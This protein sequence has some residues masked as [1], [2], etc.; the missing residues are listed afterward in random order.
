MSLTSRLSASLRR[1]QHWSFRFASIRSQEGVA[2][3]YARIRHPKPFMRRCPPPAPSGPV[4]IIGGDSGDHHQISC[5]ILRAGLTVASSNGDPHNE[6]IVINPALRD[7]KLVSPN[8]LVILFGYEDLRSTYL[9]LVIE[10]GGV[11]LC[12]N[13]TILGKLQSLGLPLERTYTFKNRGA[14]CQGM[15]RYLLAVRSIHLE[16]YEWSEISGLLDLPQNPKLCLSLPEAAERRKRFTSLYAGKFRIVDGIRRDPGWVGAAASY[17]AIAQACLDQQAAPVLICEDDVV[18]PSDVDERIESVLSYLKGQEW[19]VFS[20]LLTDVGPD[21]VVSRVDRYGESTFIHLNRCA[22]LVFG[23]Y[24]YG[25]LKRLASWN[26]ET[27]HHI[28][29]YLERSDGLRVVTTLPFL[30]DHCDELA[31]TVW[32]FR[33]KRYRNMIRK[34][35]ARLA[36]LVRDYECRVLNE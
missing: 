34:S 18:L 10:R 35:E 30:A 24:N 36:Q 6:R 7:L 4:S 13:I 14:L 26:E 12:D 29:R 8:D 23:I 25:A 33:N 16:E 27:K 11:V 31:S 3:F 28:D 19:D 22:G 20:G 5:A 1:F 15:L 9:R 32:G 17:R 2:G 21:Y